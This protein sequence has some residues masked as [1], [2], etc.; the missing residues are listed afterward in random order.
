MLRGSVESREVKRANEVKACCAQEACHVTGLESS[1]SNNNRQRGAE[2]CTD[3][4]S[5]M[6]RYLTSEC[7]KMNGQCSLAPLT[8][9]R[10][11][12]EFPIL[13]SVLNIAYSTSA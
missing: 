8:R 1:I 11:F 5:S 6:Y 4:S 9:V 10:K 3:E 13:K 2:V 7:F 12:Q